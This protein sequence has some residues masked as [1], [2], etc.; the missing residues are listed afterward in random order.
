ME[1]INSTTPVSLRTSLEMY[2]QQPVLPSV[3]LRELTLGLTRAALAAAA[4][5]A[6]PRPPQLFSSPLRPSFLLPTSSSSCPQ[7]C[8][9][10][11]LRLNLRLASSSSE[12]DAEGKESGRGERERQKE[13]MRKPAGEEGEERTPLHDG[14]K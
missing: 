13:R 7:L 2:L 12:G 1:D 4:V 11:P 8:I 5:A 3:T 14:G 9:P 6:A 10:A